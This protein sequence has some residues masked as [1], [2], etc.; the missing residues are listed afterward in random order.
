MPALLLFEVDKIWRLRQFLGV[1]V[2]SLLNPKNPTAHL[3]SKKIK[4]KLNSQKQRLRPAEI[5]STLIG[6]SHMKK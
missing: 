1:L 5:C 4:E 6:P 3:Y 2:S